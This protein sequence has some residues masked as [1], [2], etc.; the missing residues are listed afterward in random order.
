ML[1]LRYFFRLILAFFDRF[2]TILLIALIFG[3]FTF[4]V[5]RNIFERTLVSNELIGVTGKYT[6]ST[7]PTSILSMISNGLTVLN[8]DGSVS[9]SIAKNWETPDRGKTW[10]FKIDNNIL[11]HD[12]KKIK[13]SDL[14]F[15]YTDVSVSYPADD[16]VEFKLQ[17]SYSAFPYIVS[18]PLFKK[19]LLGVSDWKV[20]TLKLSGNFIERIT[21]VNSENKKITY[22]FFPSEE[23]TKLAFKLGQVNTIKDIPDKSD[24]A[25]WK[26]INVEEK[27]N[28]GEYAGVF[29]N[30]QDKILAEKTI[31][32]ALSYA[33][34]KR[35]Y[36][37]NRAI[38]P[39]SP[40][41]WA[42]NSQIKT[43]SYDP[44]KA[45]NII[46]QFKKD[47]KT[48]ELEINLLTYPNLLSTAEKIS[49]EWGD[50]GVKVNIQ[51]VN[52]EPTDY[53]ALLA[54]F[55]APDDP[56]QYSMWHS[57][58]EIT[59][60]T[61]YQNPRI[62]KLLE[63]GRSEIDINT[64]KKI[65]LDFQRFLVEDAPVAFLFFPKT[66]TISR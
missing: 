57:T 49:K 3:I 52:S 25:S 21:L 62:D 9:P 46:S 58:Q 45:K 37:D 40:N 66:Y 24:F 17:N 64:R 50:V 15:N 14:T 38:S 22:R 29:F 65:Y 63:D 42:Y 43:Y 59:N 39:I 19:G 12:G 26:R 36:G 4:F 54:V 5:L 47:S 7:L 1:S 11:W 2:K 20:K 33:I 53:Q 10:I 60:L 31:R 34:D 8:E 55:D 27:I 32:Q 44:E 48:D 30:T 56:D 18:K 35:V 41:S 23:R 13:S 6:T 61:K 28:S 51:S 16:V